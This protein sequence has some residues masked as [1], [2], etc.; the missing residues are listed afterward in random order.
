MRVLVDTHAMLWWLRAD[1]RLSERASAVI[2]NG[3]N[4]LLWSVASSWEVGVKLGLGKLRIDR[5]VH[6][7]FAHLLGDQGLRSLPITHEHCA[8]LSSLPHHHRDPFDRMLVVQ[9]QTESV[10]ILS[11]DPKLSRYDIEILW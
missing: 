10:P 3:D 8:R 6:R 5:P 4:E 2:A 9:A 7:L 11:A 1:E